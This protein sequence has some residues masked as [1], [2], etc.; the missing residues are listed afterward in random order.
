M[1]ANEQNAKKLLTVNE[2]CE[3]LSIGRVKLFELIGNGE[4]RSV[5]IGRARRI[6][7]GALDDFVEQKLSETLRAREPE[8]DLQC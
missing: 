5:K 2:A 4:I 1:N 3:F 6:P 8:R 7:A